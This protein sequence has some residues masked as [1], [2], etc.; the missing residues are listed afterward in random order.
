MKKSY[1]WMLVMG[2]FIVH[3]ALAQETNALDFDGFDDK[4]TVPGASALITSGTGISLTCWAY[5]VNTAPAFPDFDGFAG[6]RDDFTADFYLLQ[7][8][9]A[10]TVE[11]RFRN[12]SGQAF[13]L[14]HAGL[15]VNTW[16]FLALTY[17]GSQLSLNING[18]TV[19]STPAN[20]AIASN[21]V[22][23]FI[24]NVYYQ[25]TDFLLHG[26]V[27]EVSLWNRALNP[28]EISCIY[29]SGIDVSDSGLQ[30]YYK[31]DQGTGGGNN[32]GITS[33][34]PSKGSINGALEGFV[35]SGG[36]SNFVTSPA[37]GTTLSATL[38]PGEVYTFN[39]QQLTAAGVYGASLP[40]G[41]ACDSVVI[42]NLSFSSVNTQLSNT[43]GVLT[44]L[45]EGDY[46]QWLDCNNGH[47][48]IPGAIGQQYA[49][50][51]SG[52]YA[53]EVTQFN[54]TDTSAC[55]EVIITGSAE[56]P[57]QGLV[58][59]YP[60]PAQDRVWVELGREAGSRLLM[61]ED[62]FGRCIA[63]V[64]TSGESTVEIPLT[65]MAAGLY[66][67]RARSAGAEQ[68]LRLLKQ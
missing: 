8:A 51:Q 62:A 14:A 57:V 37:V 45:A 19:A 47:A 13:T 41:S 7:I 2:L 36:A 20:G 35:L 64:R 49:P 16:Q 39:G 23:L 67:V 68:V 58:K 9:P 29:N 65:G 6:L 48:E 24:G 17:N 40:S 63:K 28:N 42:L 21:F 15:V 18:V 44:S 59:V 50:V 33:L 3:P 1:A 30:L 11:G 22:D 55:A 46:W 4:V 34:L 61:V 54:C 52:S 25:G 12:S 32:A 56:A 27:D 31:M 60:N 43:G 10:N 26:R 66:V 5:P 53:V 38:C